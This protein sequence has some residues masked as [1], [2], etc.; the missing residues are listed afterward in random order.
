MEWPVKL[1]TKVQF[2]DDAA[3]HTLAVKSEETV[4]TKSLLNCDCL[5]ELIRPMCAWNDLSKDKLSL[6]NWIKP[7]LPLSQA[8]TLKKSLLKCK[9]QR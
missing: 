3:F 7:S 6:Y 9:W 8:A 1:K 5:I 2:N 4:P